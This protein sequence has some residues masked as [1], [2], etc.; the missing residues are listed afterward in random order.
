MIPLA[1][2]IG[3]SLP[4]MREHPRPRPLLRY[5]LESLLL[6]L[7]L[8]GPPQGFLL[9]LPLG[10]LPFGLLLGLLLELQ[11]APM[12]PGWPPHRPQPQGPRRSAS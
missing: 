11:R 5:L 7:L 8:P 2:G 3:G 9:G 6:E 4:T 10:L 12:L 1:E